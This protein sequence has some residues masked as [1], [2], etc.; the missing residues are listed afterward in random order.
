MNYCII[1]IWFH[2]ATMQLD[3]YDTARIF[4][5]IVMLTNFNGVGSI[6]GVKRDVT[7]QSINEF[8][9][10]TLQNWSSSSPENV[11]DLTKSFHLHFC[12]DSCIISTVAIDF[13]KS[14]SRLPQPCF[15]EHFVWSFGSVS[16]C[17][18]WMWRA[19]RTKRLL[20]EW[21]R[22]WILTFIQAQAESED[23]TSNTSSR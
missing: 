3:V 19:S 11:T 14:N 22:Q 18:H 13:I 1:L 2:L 7:N 5:S 23:K 16:K 17:G 8:S 4:E 10:K 20:T 21:R 12:H 15:H 6:L 9:I